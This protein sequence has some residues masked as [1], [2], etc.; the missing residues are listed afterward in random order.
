[1]S[2]TEEAPNAAEA[3]EAEYEMKPLL[4]DKGNPVL[5]EN[6]DPVMVPVEEEEDGKELNST[7]CLVKMKL[8]LCQSVSRS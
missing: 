2:E 6:G 1:M 5:D 3:D 7:H 4:D 8:D